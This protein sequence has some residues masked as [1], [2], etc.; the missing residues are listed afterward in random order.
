MEVE[1]QHYFAEETMLARYSGT[2][3]AMRSMSVVSLSS[4]P[5]KNFCFIKWLEWLSERSP[6]HRCHKLPSKPWSCCHSSSAHAAPPATA[7]IVLRA[8]AQK[9]IAD[10]TDQ[11][12][13]ASVTGKARLSA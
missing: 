13:A 2:L 7:E 5:A 9:T 11:L 3:V 4:S 10:N 8:N 1:G 12:L 6:S